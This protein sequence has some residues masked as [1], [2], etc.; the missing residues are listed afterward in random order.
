MCLLQNVSFNYRKTQRERKFTHI[1][2]I[3]NNNYYV[4]YFLSNFYYIHYRRTL[5]ITVY[6][7]NWLSEVK[8]IRLPLILLFLS[9]KLLNY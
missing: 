7:L 2:M 1:S 6:T 8:D 4:W 9:M 5:S 3:I